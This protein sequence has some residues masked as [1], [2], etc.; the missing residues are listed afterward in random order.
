M[1]ATREQAIGGIVALLDAFDTFIEAATVARKERIRRPIEKRLESKLAALFTEQG[2]VFLKGFARLES[3]LPKEDFT[4][5]AKPKL[6]WETFY[7][8]SSDAVEADFIAAIVDAAGSAMVAGA[9]LLISDLKLDVSFDLKNPRAV[10]YLKSRGAANVT[11]ISETTRE[12]LKTIITE[13]VEQGWSYGRLAA[14]IRERFAEFA[15]GAPITASR[16]R[17]IALTEI[18][19]AYEAGNAAV[20]G[21]LTD[22]GLEMEKSWLTVGD[23][24]VDDICAEN[25][26]EGWIPVDQAHKS[27]D[28]QPLAHPNCRCTELYRRVGSE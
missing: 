1:I 17:L 6:D 19:N 18:G 11:A 4:E 12:Y 2:N 5:A 28:M 14:R 26:A 21:D 27:G 3:K 23:G 7:Q 25:E 20:V 8:A 10:A 16:A 22:S 13:G 9:D 15:D 24:N